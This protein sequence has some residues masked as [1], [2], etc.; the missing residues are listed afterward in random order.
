[1][2]PMKRLGWLKLIVWHLEI[3]EC[4]DGQD[5]ESCSA[6]DVGPGGLHIAGDWG[7][8]HW[9]D[10]GRC[11]ALELIAELNVMAHADHLRGRVA[12]SLGR[13]AFTSRAN[14]LKMR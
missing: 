12:S 7:T 14:C 8:K 10:T 11:R 2:T 4:L 6:I 13:T 3:V 9:E 1:M 5:I